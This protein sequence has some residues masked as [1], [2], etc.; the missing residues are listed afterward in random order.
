MKKQW[1]SAATKTTTTAAR[2]YIFGIIWK[3]RSYQQQVRS[4]IIDSK[5]YIGSF[6]VMENM[7]TEMI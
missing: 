2:K 3:C 1:T 6:Y 7:R 5:Y 4:F